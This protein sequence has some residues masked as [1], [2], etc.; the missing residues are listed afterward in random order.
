M[1]VLMVCPEADFQLMRRG[2]VV[3]ATRHVATL[4]TTLALMVELPDRYDHS[5][6]DGEDR[7]HRAELE[8]MARGRPAL[9]AGRPDL[10]C[11]RA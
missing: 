10:E 5:D 6:Q 7:Y 8:L 11:R 1:I 4:L 9:L 2:S 3:L